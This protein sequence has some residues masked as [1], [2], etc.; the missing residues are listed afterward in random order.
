MNSPKKE[1]NKKSVNVMAFF[2]VLEAIAVA[3]I[4]LGRFV[5]DWF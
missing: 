2:F 1:V 4:L 5:F 3:L